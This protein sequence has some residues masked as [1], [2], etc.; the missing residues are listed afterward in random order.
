VVLAVVESHQ[1]E[2]TVFLREGHSL[3]EGPRQQ[4]QK[5]R[6]QVDAMV[7]RMITDG[8]AAGE[9][10]PDLDVRLTRM[11]I[12]G[13]CNWTYQWFRPDGAMSS[14]EI[15][16]YFAGVLLRGLSNVDRPEAPRPPAPAQPTDNHV[17]NHHE[18]TFGGH[19]DAIAEPSDTPTGM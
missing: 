3:P 12:L 13:M 16:D 5:E 10:R 17:H 15:A 8:V 2:V 18:A 11:A 6:D 19:A 9:L 4:I 1:A 7:D 14:G